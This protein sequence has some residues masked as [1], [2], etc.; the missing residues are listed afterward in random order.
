[1]AE[2]QAAGK[3]RHLGLSECSARTL[4]RAVAVAPIAAAQMEF[5]PFALEIESAQTNF[6][7]TA[8]RL[9]VAIVAY[10]PLGRGFLTGTI[11]SRDDFDDGD[12]R[13]AHPRFSEE[14]FASNLKLV[15]T[16]GAIARDKGCTS[17]QLSLA[18]VL[19]QGEG[20]CLVLCGVVWDFATPAVLSR[21][22][23]GRDWFELCVSVR[24]S[25]RLTPSG[26]ILSRSRERSASSTLR[27]TLG[28]C[29]SS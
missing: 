26:Q 1:M 13:K 18:W 12:G 27:R 19:A 22:P 25:G 6:L 10:S 21:V 16:L 2:L 15:E 23:R 5:S 24:V 7:A 9:G 14:H 17:G 3:I 4:Q 11:R 20:E 8:R 29:A 28:P